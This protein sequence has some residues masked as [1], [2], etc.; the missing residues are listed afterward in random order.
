MT[1]ATT[2]QIAVTT[3]VK[4]SII[5]LDTEYALDTICA[6]ATLLGPV[7]LATFQTAVL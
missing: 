6:T 3:R 4:D 1:L 7:L 5:A 2:G